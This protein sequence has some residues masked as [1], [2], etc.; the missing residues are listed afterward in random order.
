MKLELK[1][2]NKWLEAT[3][4]NVSDEGTEENEAKTQV[5]C[6]SF[7]GH[8][9]HIAML[10]AK[11]LEYGTELDEA[12]VKELEDSYVSPTQAE[13]DAIET[14]NKI[15]EAKAYLASTDFKMTIDYYATL[16]LEQ[17]AELTTK[18][19]EARAFLKGQGL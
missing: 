5:H 16:T 15:S 11:A 17:Q 18:R 2:S 13:L 4:Y 6:E 8:P 3:W 9:E 19:A 10:R 7:S 1:L 14:A 12:I